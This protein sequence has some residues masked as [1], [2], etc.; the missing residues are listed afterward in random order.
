[1]EVKKSLQVFC[2]HNYYQKV[3]NRTSL[4]KVTLSKYI[5][6]RINRK[7]EIPKWGSFGCEACWS[8]DTQS[9]WPHPPQLA[10][11]GEVSSQDCCN[12]LLHVTHASQC[13]SRTQYSVNSKGFLS[14]ALSSFSFSFNKLIFRNARWRI[15]IFFCH[16]YLKNS[17]VCIFF[18]TIWV[19]FIKL[20]DGKV[21]NENRRSHSKSHTGDFFSM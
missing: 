16:I 8:W 10:W 21:N 12:G 14:P 5:N 4:Y 6:L 1:M 17:F 2:E 15:F 19:H 7:D 3:V 20:E 18:L 9:V 13:L 11:T